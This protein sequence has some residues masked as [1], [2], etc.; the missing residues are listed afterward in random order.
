MTN[1]SLDPAGNGGSGVA[2]AVAQLAHGQPYGAGWR[3]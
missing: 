2:H 1:M 3:A